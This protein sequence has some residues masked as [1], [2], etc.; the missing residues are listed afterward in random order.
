MKYLFDDDMDFSGMT[1]RQA[2]DAL[3]RLGVSLNDYDSHALDIVRE[4]AEQKLRDEKE[5]YKWP[6]P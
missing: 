5:G 4:Y 2:L 6:N 3:Y 1:I